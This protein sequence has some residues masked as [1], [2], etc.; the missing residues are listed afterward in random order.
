MDNDQNALSAS[1]GDFSAFAHA[2]HEN[3]NVRKGLTKREYFAGLI[4]AQ[5]SPV[6]MVAGPAAERAVQ[7]AD[8]LLL[9]LA[10]PVAQ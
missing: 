7:F 5:L 6:Y 4:M 2:G 8:A 3:Y 9:E 1:N 10:K